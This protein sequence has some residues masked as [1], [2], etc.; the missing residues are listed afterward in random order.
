M[1]RESGSNSRKERSPFP[2]E[3]VTSIFSAVA[4]LMLGN[5]VEYVSIVNLIWE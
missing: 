2:K 3:T 5:T 1:L 4:R